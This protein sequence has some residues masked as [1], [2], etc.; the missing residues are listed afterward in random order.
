MIIPQEI[1]DSRIFEPSAETDKELL[2]SIALYNSRMNDNRI[3]MR[4]LTFFGSVILS[5]NIIMLISVGALGMKIGG[6][7]LIS[8]R[9]EWLETA[10][11]LLFI[12]GYIYFGLRK[13]NFIALTLFSAPLVLMD[14]R[15][16]FITAANVVLTVVYTLKITKLRGI[17]GYPQFHAIKI[18]QKETADKIPQKPIDKSEQM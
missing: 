3:K 9:I 18:I 7:F 6:K 13:R 15:C 14:A 10:V 5:L 4:K 17:S 11:L 16:I 1:I 2:M 12:A 8:P